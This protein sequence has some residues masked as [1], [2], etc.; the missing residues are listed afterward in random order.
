MFNGK[1]TLTHKFDTRHRKKNNFSTKPSS[2][3]YKMCVAFYY[4]SVSVFPLIMGQS[5]CCI[6]YHE[7]ANCLTI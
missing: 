4:M 3:T 6:I 5:N 7:Q 2:V 1:G